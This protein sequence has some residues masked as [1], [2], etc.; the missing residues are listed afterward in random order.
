MARTVL[1]GVVFTVLCAC[2][3]PATLPDGGRPRQVC[4]N[5]FTVIPVKTID[6]NGMPVSDA[7]VLATNQSNGNTLRGTTNGSCD[8]AA[9][10]EEIGNGQLEITATAGTLKTMMGFIVEV[11]CGECDCTAMPATAT[12]ILQ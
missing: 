1:Y 5:T 2:G 6:L 12:V 7:T 4:E 10:T 8:T 3:R 11:V 9:F